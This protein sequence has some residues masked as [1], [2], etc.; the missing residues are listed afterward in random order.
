MSVKQKTCSF[1][2]R[3][4]KLDRNHR[5]YIKIHGSI[6]PYDKYLVTTGQRRLITK[7]QKQALHLCH[8]DFEGL[9]QEEAAKK[10]S[11]S[12]RAICYLLVAVEK[13]LPDYFPIITKL[14]AQTY[15][16]YMIEGWSVEEIARYM[17]K[18][19]RTVQLTLQRARDKGM[20][21]TKA[22][23][24]ILS[25]EPSMDADVKHKF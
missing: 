24:R 11:I 9:T 16:C 18:S 2:L 6:S 17:E 4:A 3:W 21:F 7:K 12:R 8:Q 22:K 15:H 25:Y 14:E 20:Y 10:M 1:C 13:V 5:R 23:G 19:Q